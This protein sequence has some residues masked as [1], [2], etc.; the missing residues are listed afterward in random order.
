MGAKS[1]AGFADGKI[2]EKSLYLKQK[3][4]RHETDCHDHNVCRCWT[5]GRVSTPQG[6]DSGCRLTLS[7]KNTGPSAR[8]HIV[9]GIR[10]T[11]WTRMGWIII[12][13]IQT[14]NTRRKYRLKEHI[15]YLSIQR[16]HWNREKNT[17]N[18]HLWI[19]LIR[20]R[21]RRQ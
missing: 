14:E 11:L 21:I 5:T 7:A 6:R 20:N 9:Q 19:L 17:I 18:I 15:E 13:L 10:L 3:F 8:M 1:Q 4:Q 16:E 12:C 2:R